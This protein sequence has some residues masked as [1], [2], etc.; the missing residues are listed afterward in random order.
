MQLSS[1]VGLRSLQGTKPLARPKDFALASRSPL[2]IDSRGT[3]GHTLD[4][5]SSIN[6]TVAGLP[7]LIEYPAGSNRTLHDDDGNVV[8]QKKM[9]HHY[10]EIPGTIGRDGDAVDVMIGPD[11]NAAYAYIVHMRD[12]GPDAGEREDEDKAMVGF[13]SADVAKAAFLSHYP[14]NFFAGMTVLPM[15]VFGQKSRTAS[16][17]HH[18][19]KIHASKPHCP[20][21]GSTKC[22]LMP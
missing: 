22:S 20:H 21:C 7:V 14:E 1:L 17:P 3:R 15:A 4:Q 11:K 18:E 2:Q 19:R 12:M 5:P 6:R 8:F 10:G 16:L 9:K 13:A